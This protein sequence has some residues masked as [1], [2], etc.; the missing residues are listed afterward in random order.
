MLKF[1]NKVLKILNKWLNPNGAP[2]PP[3]PLSGKWYTLFDSGYGAFTT[4][5]ISNY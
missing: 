3:P 4:Y 5:N 2:V 1:N